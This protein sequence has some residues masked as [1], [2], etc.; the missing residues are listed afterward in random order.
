MIRSVPSAIAEHPGRLMAPPMLPPSL[1][2]TL[3][4][5]LDPTVAAAVAAVPA[6]STV[7]ADGLAAGRAAWP[8]VTVGEAR[9]LEHVGGAIAGVEDAATLPAL[10]FAD[11]YLA[12]ACSDGDEIAIRSLTAH[13]RREVEAALR[14]LRLG[15]GQADEVLQRVWEMLLVASD[16]GH[17][18]IADYRGRGDLRKWLRATALRVAYRLLEQAG[19]DVALGD[20][21]LAIPD[22]APDPEIDYL[23]Q[24]YGAEFRAAFHAAIA[25]L[26]ARDRS[27]L[28]RHHLDGLTVNQLSALHGVHRATLSRWLTEARERV[29]DATRDELRRRLQIGD[30]ELESLLRLVHSRLD[31]SLERAFADD[32]R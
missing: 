5:R 14:T 27:L 31:V 9:F 7:L 13:Y 32:R 30:S 16:D 3:L 26:S 23:K 29:L 4:R 20:D 19:R 10:R 6:L 18:R 17:R 28:R 21:E 22:T 12:A 11:L 15:P 1:I 8:A 25:V 24:R 2:A